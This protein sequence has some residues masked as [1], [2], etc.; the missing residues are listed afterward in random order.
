MNELNVDDVLE[1][2]GGAKTSTILLGCASI[3]ACF[4]GPAGIALGV[5]LAIYTM[6]TDE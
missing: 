1:I 4:A 3:A 5:G 2:S 6:A